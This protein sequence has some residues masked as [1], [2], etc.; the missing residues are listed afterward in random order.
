MVT[1]FYILLFLAIW[2]FFYESVVAASLR[3]GYR[4]D[5]FEL[6]DKLRNLKIN[7][8]LSEKD[9][10]IFTLLDNSICNMI[11]AMSIISLGNYFRLKKAIEKNEKVK[12]SI[13]RTTNFIETADHKELL[14]LDKEIQKL[15]SKVLVIN[16]GGWFMILM[17][18]LFILLTIVFFSLQF[19]RLNSMLVKVSSRLIYSA[20]A[21]IKDK[22]HIPFA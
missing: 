14:A 5:F 15:G 16:N 9:E 22:Y 4:Y 2:H 7:N 3:Q 10:K 8:E 18:P 6:R 19:E 17:L 12:S 21:S 11:D 13:E 20:N 1:L